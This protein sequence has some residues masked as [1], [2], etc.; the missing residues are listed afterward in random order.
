MQIV[1]YLSFL[2]GPYFGD[3]RNIQIFSLGLLIIQVFAPYPNILQN[4]RMIPVYFMI[5]KGNF[6]ILDRL[7]AGYMSMSPKLNEWPCMLIQSLHQ[8]FY[9]YWSALGKIKAI[10]SEVF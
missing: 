2:T 10:I 3:A 4:P 8:L 1:Q 9:I 5:P 6:D 7:S